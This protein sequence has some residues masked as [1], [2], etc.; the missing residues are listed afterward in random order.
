MA[1]G[2]LGGRYR[3]CWPDQNVIGGRIFFLDVAN[4]VMILV[5]TKPSLLRQA[6]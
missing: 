5:F 6:L 3:F 1:L 4:S 2:M